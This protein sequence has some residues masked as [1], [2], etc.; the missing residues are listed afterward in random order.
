MPI[1]KEQK[2]YVDYLLE[3]M[4]PIGKVYARPM[5]GG[6][7][8]FL[9]KLMFALIS[10]GMLYFKTDARSSTAF[11]QRDLEAFSYIK[12][13]KAFKLNYYQ[14]PEETLEDAKEMIPWAKQAYAI[15]LSVNAEKTRK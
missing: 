9:D 6:H 8:V 11:K 10:D 15:A 1:T 3:L 4:Q 13:G 5:F 14:A 7:G 12:K 2:H